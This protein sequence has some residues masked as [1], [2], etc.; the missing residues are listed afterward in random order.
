[1]DLAIAVLD[2]FGS[3]SGL[4]AALDNYQNATTAT[5]TTSRPHGAST[6]RISLVVKKGRRAG[7]EATRRFVRRPFVL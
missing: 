7:L 2:E 6:T 4:I 1:L 5:I 3:A